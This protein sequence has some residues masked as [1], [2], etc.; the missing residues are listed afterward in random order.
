[1][2]RTGSGKTL[3]YIIPLLQRLQRRPANPVGPRGLI[4]CPNRELALQILRVGKDLARGLSQD[5][6]DSKLQ[7]A[8]IIGG[9]DMDEQFAIMTGKPDMYVLLL[10]AKLT[11]SIIATP[12]RWLHVIIEMTLDLRSIELVVYDEADRC[13]SSLPLPADGCRL[14]E[15]GFDTQLRE[16]VHRLPA[17]RQSLMFSATLPTDVS[18]F[19]KAGLINP[20]LIR[21]DSDTKLSPDL[22]L[23]FLP[24][25]PYE[26]DAA[27]LVLLEKSKNLHGKPIQTVVFVSTKHHVEYIITL[28]RGAAYRVNHVYG[29]LDQIARKQQLEG[30]RQGHAD[31]L[32]VTDVAARGLDM[33]DLDLVINY[34]FPPSPRTFLHRVGRTARAGR[35]GSA[36]SLLTAEDIP[37]ALDLQR[38]LSRPILSD[39][40]ETCGRIDA[41]SLDNKIEFIHDS[42]ILSCPDLPTLGQVM[43]RGQKMFARTRNRASDK[44]YRDAKASTTTCFSDDTPLHQLF[45]EGPSSVGSA[46]QRLLGLLNDFGSASI[47]G[48]KRSRKPILGKE[49]VTGDSPTFKRVRINDV[50]SATIRGCNSDN[51]AGGERLPRYLLFHGRATYWRRDGA[52]V[53]A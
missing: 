3:A 23:A 25:R 51:S 43:R 9:E 53:G 47:R 14:F 21:L 46:R 4:L 50:S 39:L 20:L 18:D 15:M 38:F 29:S 31:I 27:L 8:L 1:M 45:A 7:W 33:P 2:A 17:S 34:D 44:S 42:L 36:W 48:T 52:R 12:G 16:I 28:L 32:V 40:G 30:F 19:A 37:Y 6:S 41:Q 10:R 5:S 22:K 35:S 13:V 24:V 26:K 49:E 11:S